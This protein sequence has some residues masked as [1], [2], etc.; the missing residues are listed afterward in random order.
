MRRYA[1]EIFSQKIS[2]VQPR[3]EF[4]TTQAL[5]SRMGGLGYAL[6]FKRSRIPKHKL[7]SGLSHRLTAAT[8]PSTAWVIAGCFIP[9]AIIGRGSCCFCLFGSTFF[10]IFFHHEHLLFKPNL[11]IP[12]QEIKETQMLF[13]HFMEGRW[14]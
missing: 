4:Y 7:S 6:S 10:N 1:P 3:G 12:P 14:I 11:I 13:A 2:E 8:N 9:T 5:P